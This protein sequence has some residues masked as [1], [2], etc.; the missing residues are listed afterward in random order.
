[1]IRNNTVLWCEKYRPHTIKDCILPDLLKS[2]LQSYVDNKLI[3]NLILSGSNG[4][5]KTSAAL[6]MV[7][8]LDVEYLF[9]NAALKR[10]I[11]TLRE[12]IMDFAST[13]SFKGTRKYVILDEFDGASNILQEG[14]KSFIET[15]S[16]N[17]G[18]IFTCNNIGKI[19]QAIIS[20]SDVLF[21]NF[22]KDDFQNLGK[23][24]YHSI[25]S[26]L[27]KEEII[28]NRVVIS[29]LIS[30]YYPDFRKILVIIQS[31][32]SKSKEIDTGILANKKDL[33][34]SELIELLKSKS[35]N[36]MR[37]FVGENFNFFG[38]FNEFFTALYEQM[39][40][41]IESKHLPLL[42][43]IMNEY[44]FQNYFVSDKELNTVAFLTKVMYD[45]SWR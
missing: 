18:F 9:I 7:D 15:F 43:N 30:K 41:K 29:K 26:I 8:E 31:Y 32:A 16:E 1:M 5:G 25:L 23:E 10:G 42:T 33:D 39:K 4:L 2:L 14:L 12:E 27:D 24:F 28:Y 11:D 21:F 40:N 3:P 36:D 22:T 6:A 37:K 13:V 45:I 34:L 17:T 19:D 20:R 38:E 35:W 44:D